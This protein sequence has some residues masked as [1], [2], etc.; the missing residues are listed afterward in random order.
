MPAV[1]STRLTSEGRRRT[2]RSVATDR[3]D[4]LAAAD[5]TEPN[6]AAEPRLNADAADPIEPTESTEPTEP[7]ERSESSDHSDHSERVECF[8][9]PACIVPSCIIPRCES[10][11]WGVA[12]SG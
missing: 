3:S 10:C 9:S 12:A 1:I 7:I 6:E 2:A 5:R 11:R 4:Q 8:T